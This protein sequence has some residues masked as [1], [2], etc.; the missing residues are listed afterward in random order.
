MCL[1]S[2]AMIAYLTGTSETSFSI[3]R[4]ANETINFKCL[5]H[6]MKSKRAFVYV[7][8][9]G[10]NKKGLI[11]LVCSSPKTLLKDHCLRLQ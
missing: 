10:K 6:V 9:R 4:C 7:L 8:K 11:F 5:N 3:L 2:A 1:F